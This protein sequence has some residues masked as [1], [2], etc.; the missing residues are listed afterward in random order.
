MRLPPSWKLLVPGIGVKRWVALTLV[1]TIVFAFGALCLVGNEEMRGLYTVLLQRLPFLWRPV[2]GGVL[3]GLGLV[4][5]L[6][7]LGMAIRSITAA[8]SPPGA[9]SL[10]EALYQARVL[11]SAPKVVAVGGGTGL[12]TLLRALKTYTANLIAVVTVMDTGGS[13][14]RLRAELD[15]LPPGDVRNCLLALAE[16][17]ARM[18]RLFSFRFPGGEGLAGHSLGNLL[19]TGLDQLLGG[20]DRAVEEAS[21]ILS[22]RGEV[23]P[24]TL[25]R[26]DLVARM[27]DGVE[28]SGE[29]A[30][31][32]DS[33]AI[34]RIGLSTPV[35][36]HEPV[37]D[38]LQHADLI[39]LGPGSLFTSVIP[40]LLVDGIAQAI[41]RSPA[42]RYLIMNLMTQPGETQGFTAHDHL[43]VLRDYIDIRQFSAVIVNTQPPPEE[44]LE[45]YRAEGSIPVIDDLRGPKAMGLRVIRAPLLALIEVE[46]R[47]TIKHDPAALGRVI[48]AHAP[49]FRRSWTRWFPPRGV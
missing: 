21:Y 6:L 3:V 41:G 33:R 48:A 20:F 13:S 34:Q 39:T 37:L 31:V 27:E 9:G 49:C 35:R 16:D 25:D 12:P 42:D 46:G 8:L 24:A 1:S 18:Q 2:F 23:L 14:G 47:P 10:T 22:V 40:S 17:E 15:V 28:V 32:E 30:I 5:A 7:G 19:L 11:P 45:R 36:P 43:R 38:A 26:A 44:I 4:G 29:I